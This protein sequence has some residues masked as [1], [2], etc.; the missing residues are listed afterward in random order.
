MTMMNWQAVQAEMKRLE[1][2]TPG[3]LASNEVV[4]ARLLGLDDA[5]GVPLGATVLQEVTRVGREILP[6]HAQHGHLPA[7]RFD[8][9]AL[10]W[11]A[12]GFLQGLTFAVA[13]GNVTARG[14]G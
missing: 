1:D 4:M 13:V 3:E 14:D 2:E 9:A 8:Q 7:A 12:L 6:W 10:N 5:E 11:A